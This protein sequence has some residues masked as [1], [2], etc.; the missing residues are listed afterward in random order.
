MSGR[1]FNLAE[2]VTVDERIDRFWAMYPAPIGSIQTEIVWVADDGSSVAIRA[3]VY[4]DD[5]ILATG[6]AQEERGPAGANRTSWWENGETSAIGRALANMGMSL[7]KQRPSREEMAKVARGEDTPP[8]PPRRTYPPPLDAIHDPDAP[9]DAR[10][11]ALHAYYLGATTL[12]DLADRSDRVADSGLD[13]AVRR[14]ALTWH[15]T[16][17]QE[18]A[19]AGVAG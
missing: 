14:A 8:A 4:V 19:P 11:A 12:A 6:I 18:A 3:T 16:R 10:K 9:A 15:R 7:S 5:R 1:G 13:A 17:L 2:Y